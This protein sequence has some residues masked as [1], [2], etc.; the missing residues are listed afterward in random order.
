MRKKSEGQGKSY[1]TLNCT[2]TLHIFEGER[3]SKQEEQER[4]KKEQER[5]EQS[6]KDNG[7]KKIR[8]QK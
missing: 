1:V 3:K 2:E 4:T 5:E 7:K 6:I 8:E